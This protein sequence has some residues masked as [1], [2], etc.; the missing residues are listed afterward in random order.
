M[1]NK[2]PLFDRD[3]NII[4]VMGTCQSYEE[5]SHFIRPYLE[6]SKAIDF[7]KENYNEKISIDDLASMVNLSTRTV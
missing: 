3:N 5:S 6:L 1:T 2:V 4:G 7:I